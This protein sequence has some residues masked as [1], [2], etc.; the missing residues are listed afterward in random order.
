MKI[1]ILTGA[2]ALALAVAVPYSSEARTKESTQ[3]QFQSQ[4]AYPSPAAKSATAQRP[5]P[6]HGKVARIDSPGRRVTLATKEGPGRTFKITE[7]SV[8][9]KTG[10]PGN[11]SDLIIG[12][13]I[14]GSYVKRPD[15]TLEIKSLK[16]GPPTVAELQVREQR[17]AKAKAKA[18]EKRATEK[19]QK[20]SGY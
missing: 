7:M 11:F 6:F 10:N 13:E 3:Q 12:E 18:A 5:I 9:Q 17:K 19:Q 2:L 20:Q 4:Q 16:V 14:R 15:G 1:R 8:I